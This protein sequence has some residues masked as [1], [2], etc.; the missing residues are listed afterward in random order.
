MKLRPPTL[1]SNLPPPPV[2]LPMAGCAA[3]A[4]LA[5]ALTWQAWEADRALTRVAAPAVAAPAAATTATAEQPAPA[6]DALAQSR[7]F[8]DVTDSPPADTTKDKKA[9][10]VASG[11]APDAL[12]DANIGLTL[13]GIVFREQAEARR[14][15][16]RGGT[17]PSVHTRA[18][19]VGQNVADGVVVRFI[20]PRRVVVEVRGELQALTLPT[21]S[22][23]TGMA[24]PAGEVALPEAMPVENMDPGTGNP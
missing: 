14:A 1:P 23:A 13:Q 2:L 8:G 4:L 6:L 9:D 15:L 24:S 18:F 10:S 19:A 16:I 3:L 12:P 17:T 21:P 20:E 11:K 7:L 22:V 5:L